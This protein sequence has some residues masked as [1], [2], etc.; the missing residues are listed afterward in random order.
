M[1]APPPLAPA[2]RVLQLLAAPVPASP[3]RERR[4][5]DLLAVAGIAIVLLLPALFNGYPGL[6]PDTAEYILRARTLPP[7]PIRAP[8]YGVWLWATSAGTSLWLP[9]VAQSA[10]L[11]ALVWRTLLALG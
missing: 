8:G 2:R 3:G 9:V 6:F 5:R 1:A 4:G 11:A 10:L 7:S